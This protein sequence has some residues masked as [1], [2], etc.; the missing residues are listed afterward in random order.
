MKSVI[1][2]EKD[3]VGVCL[4]GNEQIPA[5]HKYALC[6]IKKGEYVIKYG[7]IIGRATKRNIALKRTKLFGLT[8]NQRS[9][10]QWIT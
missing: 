7:E 10:M 2:N 9:I 6:D 8:H 1:I 3:N 4:D 5:G